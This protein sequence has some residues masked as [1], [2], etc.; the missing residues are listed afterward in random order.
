MV[1]SIYEMLIKDLRTLCLSHKAVKSFRVGDI[2]SIEQ[3]SGNDGA[4]TNSYDYMAFHLV[5]STA[6]M[7]GQSTKFEFDMVVFDL[8][9][10]DLEL[11]VIT[12]SQCLEVTRDI[13]SKFNLTDWV[14]FRYNIQLPTT[15]MIFDEAFV[16]SVAGYTTRIVVEAISPFTLCENPFN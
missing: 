14:G 13:I 6:E 11:Q 12:Q 5:P 15:S 1:G 7:N 9:K 4:F 8:C 2:S 3:P 10:D 16:N